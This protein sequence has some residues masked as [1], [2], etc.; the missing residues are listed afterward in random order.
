MALSA[1]F[2]KKHEHSEADERIGKILDGG[3]SKLKTADLIDQELTI[4]DYVHMNGKKGAYY[5]ICAEELGK[6][7]FFS[8]GILT[9]ILD[10][11]GKLG[12]D[13]RGTKIVLRAKRTS[14]SGNEYIP[15]DIL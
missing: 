6:D 8:P 5:I 10:D 15:V 12:E 13:A 4:S 1:D 14:K 9:S 2:K 11:A 3:G 7:F